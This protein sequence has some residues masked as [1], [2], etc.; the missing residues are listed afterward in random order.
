VRAFLVVAAT[1][2]LGTGPDAAASD[3]ALERMPAAL[4][5]RFALSALPPGLRP[6]ATVFVL[7]PSR[8]YALAR[9]G[10][11]GQSCFVERTEWE[12]EDYRNDLYAPLCYDRA[13]ADAQMQVWFDVAELRARGL[14]PRELRN[15]IQSRFVAGRYKAPARPG[16][17]YM[18]APLMRAYASRDLA[19][20]T[21]ATVSMPHVMYYAPGVNDVDVGGVPPPPLQPYPYVAHPGP[22]GYFMQFFGETERAAII[23]RERPLLDALC[24]YRT[25]LCLSNR[26]PAHTG[27][28][29]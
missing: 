6:D 5:I 27:G 26:G 18:T 19:D 9:R 17:S 20:R 29:Q 12:R 4:E 24:A 2:L 14:S 16:F 1:A 28:M 3:T 21:V 23:T 10:T 15:E 8:G 11:N 22:H 7:D 13:G 25:P